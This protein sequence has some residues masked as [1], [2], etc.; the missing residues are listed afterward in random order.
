MHTAAGT[1]PN[2]APDSQAVPLFAHAAINDAVTIGSYAG[3]VISEPG[4]ELF[5]A[6]CG[7]DPASRADDLAFAAA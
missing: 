5:G 6:I 4:G 3:A 2:V 1:V 7:I